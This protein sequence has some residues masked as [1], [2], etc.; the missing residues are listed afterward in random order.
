MSF[1]NFLNLPGI[2]E[3]ELVPPLLSVFELEF[4]GADEA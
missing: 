1:T 3:L 4:A 2:F